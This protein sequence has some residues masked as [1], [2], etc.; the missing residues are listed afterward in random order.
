VFDK[1]ISHNLEDGLPEI[2]T[3][4]LENSLV[5]CSDVIEHIKKPELLLSQLASISEVA[6]YVLLSTPDRD[7]ARGWIDM[8]PP[9]NT[10]H[11]REWSAN[12]FV[13]FMFDCGFKSIP[14]YGHTVNTDV[15]LVKST[16]MVVCG[17]HAA[18]NNRG[19]K[20]L[21]VA[22]I[23]HGFNEKDILPEIVRH[24][25]KNGIEIHYFDNWS[26]DGSWEIIS[27]FQNQ[28]MVIQCQRFPDAPTNQYCWQAQ[29]KKT[30]E[31]AS[32]I[33][34]DWVMHYDA[35]EIR[36]SPWGETT[37]K[38]GI[39]NVDALGYNAID[40]T[41]I[42]FRYTFK[43]DISEYF[44]DKL[45]HFEFGRRPGH[46]SQ[47]KCWKNQGKVSLAETGGHEVCFE[48][49]KVFPIKFLTKHYPLRNKKQSLQKIYIDRLPRFIEENK[50]YGWHTQYDIFKSQKRDPEWNIQ[51]LIPWH[52]K[53]FNSEY[54]VERI[55]GI[56]IL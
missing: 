47:I 49:R 37:L 38:Q 31:Y 40:F 46:F 16:I 14:F 8:G 25:N 18:L 5:I 7:R 54:L 19:I 20:N 45:T 13:R 44:E 55:S 11:V 15:N 41:V 43:N 27:D 30:E 9:A 17:S 12:E 42:D 53:Y 51:N 29:L 39:L 3:S 35:D 4:I 21:K 24:L 50:A 10:C 52:S 32:K 23:V 33:D 6:P 1:L 56:G 48:G 26:N 36:I 34:A 22:A 28:G 2:P